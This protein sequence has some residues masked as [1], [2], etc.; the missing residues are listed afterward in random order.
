M[1]TR[2]AVGTKSEFA[3]VIGR[4]KQYVSQLGRKGRLVLTSDGKVDFEAS[5]RRIEETKRVDRQG[6]REHHARARRSAGIPPES[7]T[8]HPE[9]D[10]APRVEPVDNGDQ[11]LAQIALLAAAAAAGFERWGER[12][13]EAMAALPR[14]R[15]GDVRL[16]P[17]LWEQLLGPYAVEV[18]DGERAVAG[19]HATAPRE[20]DPDDFVGDVIFGLAAGLY[21]LLPEV[22]MST[23]AH[24][25]GLGPIEA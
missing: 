21:R 16:P 23:L 4:T 5:K 2:G 6:V 25:P 13:R 11:A 7:S 3:A 1:A 19:A 12:L 20:D 14:A 9:P 18:L 22:E 15:W 17:A 10:T 24:G 8:R